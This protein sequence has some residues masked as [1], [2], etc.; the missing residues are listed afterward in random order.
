MKV[1]DSNLSKIMVKIQVYHIFPFYYL[2]L[3]MLCILFFLLLLSSAVFS[4]LTF[5]KKSFGKPIRVP[6][7]L[8]PD[9]DRRSVGPDLGPNC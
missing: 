8:D 7:G 2:T 6:N 1:N 4:K 3:C 9:Q 5:K